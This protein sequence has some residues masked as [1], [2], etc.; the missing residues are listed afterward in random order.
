VC[1]P[2][3]PRQEED[4]AITAAVREEQNRSVL[5]QAFRTGGP[6]AVLLAAQQQGIQIEMPYIRGT[7]Q[8]GIQINDRTQLQEQN[9]N[10]QLHVYRQ[11]DPADSTLV[12]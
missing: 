5:L 3:L 4:D 2:T 11:D 10:S 8:Q 9:A 1:W 7:Q 6:Q 12:S